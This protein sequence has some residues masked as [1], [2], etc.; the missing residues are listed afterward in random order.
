MGL[1][2]LGES[3][4]LT[5]YMPTSRFFAI[6]LLLFALVWAEVSILLQFDSPAKSEI[7]FTESRHFINPLT[8]RGLNLHI[9]QGDHVIRIKADD[10]KVSPREFYIFNVK[11]LNE[12]ELNN[13]TVEFNI[14][15]NKPA[16]KNLTYIR[17]I[18]SSPVDGGLSSTETLIA[19]SINTGL[20]TR[21]VY[22]NVVLKIYSNHSVLLAIK[23]EKADTEFKENKINFHNAIIEDIRTNEIVRS[24]LAILKKNTDHFYIPDQYVKLSPSGVIR[25]KGLQIRLR[26]S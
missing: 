11:Q 23:A 1:V 7:S 16:D 26:D 24:R 21:G 8:V 14:D 20:I 25:G 10:F 4:E 22:N 13:V 15:E 5:D 17:Q 18:F 19:E 2:G 3:H 6:I 9:F 12:I